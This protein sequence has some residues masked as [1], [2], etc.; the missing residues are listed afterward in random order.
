MLIVII[1]R[2]PIHELFGEAELS[3]F[4]HLWAVPNSEFCESSE[5]SF[6]GKYG[7]KVMKIIPS[8][9]VL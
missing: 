9:H 7:K 5:K 1:W 4:Q 6:N 8:A 2:E 3:L